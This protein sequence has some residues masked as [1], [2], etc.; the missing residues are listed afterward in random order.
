[1]PVNHWINPQLARWLAS[2][3]AG[4]ATQLAGGI[5]Y[6][7]EHGRGAVLPDVRHRIQI[8]RHYPHMSEI[9]AKHGPLVL[10]V[11]TCFVH[12]DRTLLI[13]GGGDKAA[14]AQ[15]KTN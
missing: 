8:S 5:E 4:A 7:L 10:R 1:L 3:P 11:L 6:L 9:R 13:C 15:H 2:L 12:E 14:W